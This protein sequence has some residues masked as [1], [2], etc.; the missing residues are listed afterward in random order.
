MVYV[1][2]PSTWIGLSRS[3]RAAQNRSNRAGDYQSRSAP[4]FAVFGRDVHF[5]FA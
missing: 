3:H 1:S 5:G 2:V 4:L